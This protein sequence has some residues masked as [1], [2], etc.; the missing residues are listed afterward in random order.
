LFAAFSIDPSSMTEISTREPMGPIA[1][2]AR[3]SSSDAASM[4]SVMRSPAA[5]PSTA[6]FVGSIAFTAPIAACSH[7]RRKRSPATA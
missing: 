3:L 6:S 1:C 5:P 4:T 2:R 7:K